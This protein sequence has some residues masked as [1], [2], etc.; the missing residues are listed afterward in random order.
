MDLKITQRFYKR[1]LSLGINLQVFRKPLPFKD[2]IFRNLT[3]SPKK[4]KKK[5]GL[6]VH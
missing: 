6:L 5:D 2:F 3:N 4:K 1:N